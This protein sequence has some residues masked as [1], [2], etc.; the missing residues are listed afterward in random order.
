MR[1]HSWVLVLEGKREV[2]ESFFIEPLTGMSHSINDDRYH[3]IESI[4]NHKNYW[5]NMQD[6][7]EGVAVRSGKRLKLV[8]WFSVL[9]M[10]LIYVMFRTWSTTLV[11]AHS[12]NTC[13]LATTSRSWY[14]RTKTIWMTTKKTWVVMSY[15]CSRLRALAPIKKYVSISPVSL[16]KPYLLIK[17]VL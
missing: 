7:S 14:F 16:L 11:T 17:A 1:V 4:W 2:P 8:V 12:G 9:W 3:G 15:D 6:C 13:F 10:I 5:V